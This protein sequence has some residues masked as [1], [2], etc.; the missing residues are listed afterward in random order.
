MKSWFN[1]LKE[2]N[3]GHVLLRDNFEWEVKC[4]GMVRLKLNDGSKKLLSNVSCVPQIKKNLISVGMLDELGYTVKIEEGKMKV[5]KDSLILLKASKRNG[6]YIFEGHTSNNV[7]ATVKEQHDK[8]LLWQKLLRH[9]NDK[10]LQELSNRGLFGRDKVTGV[11]IH[12]HCFAGKQNIV[13]FT[14]SAHTTLGIMDYIHSDLWG[15]SSVPTLGGNKYFLTFTDDFSRKSC[16]CF[17]EQRW[18][19]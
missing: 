7:V 19:F 11:D 8:T 17:E 4:I 18:S 14:T 3:Y 6:L 16:V 15:L 13:K 12:E 5:L 1:E 9:L 2:D 10:R